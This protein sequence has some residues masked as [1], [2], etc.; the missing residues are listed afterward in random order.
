MSRKDIGTQKEM[1]FLKGWEI[2]INR[3]D[4]DVSLK[5]SVV[6]KYGP[7]T[8][9]GFSNITRLSFKENIFFN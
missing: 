3:I 2:K 5:M 1:L 6:A 7:E 8:S 4:V 9:T